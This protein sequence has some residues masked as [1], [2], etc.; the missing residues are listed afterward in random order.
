[1]ATIA[2]HRGSSLASHDTEMLSYKQAMTQTLDELR[3]KIRHKLK[4]RARI[5]EGKTQR[6]VSWPAKGWT[7]E[8]WQPVVDYKLAESDLRDMHVDLQATPLS[9]DQATPLVQPIQLSV[10]TAWL[11]ESHPWT[12]RGRGGGHGEFRHHEA[13]QNA[14]GLSGALAAYGFLPQLPPPGVQSVTEHSGF[15][16]RLTNVWKAYCERTFWYAVDNIYQ[17]CN[18]AHVETSCTLVQNTVLTDE[19]LTVTELAAVVNMAFLRTRDGVLEKVK[20]IPVS[21]DS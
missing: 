13:Y 6:I 19:Y 17:H 14:C 12:E 8:V 7:Y 3:N 16:R 2:Q 9:L 1:M 18:E 20:C 21:F 4:T 10:M 15:H 11:K 5:A